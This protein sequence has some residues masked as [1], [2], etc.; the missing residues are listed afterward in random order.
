MTTK[1]ISVL[2]VLVQELI[3]IAERGFAIDDEETA[4]RCC[5]SERRRQRG[6]RRR[7]QLDQGRPHHPP[8]R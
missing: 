8:T 7:C 4:I 2:P 3:A 1:S 6:R 5:A